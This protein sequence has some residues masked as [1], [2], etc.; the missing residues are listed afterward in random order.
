MVKLAEWIKDVAQGRTAEGEPIPSVAIVAPDKEETLA[1]AEKASVM[2]KESCSHGR[3]VMIDIPAV[4]IL[5][6]ALRT[7]DILYYILRKLQSSYCR[8]FIYHQDRV[9]QWIC[10]QAG[11]NHLVLHKGHCGESPRHC[12]P[13]KIEGARVQW[14]FDPVRRRT[15][16]V[17]EGG[18]AQRD[19]REERGGPAGR[20]LLGR[21]RRQ[22]LRPPPYVGAP[23]AS[24]HGS[25]LHRAELAQADQPASPGSSDCHLSL[26]G[27]WLERDG[28]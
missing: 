24:R 1:I 14:R 6:R 3:S 11:E 8:R 18:G 19:A 22:G 2:W 4:H 7:R 26:A 5:S 28:A 27:H 12:Q 9:C 16:A 13:S 20:R 25:P 15:A 23:A 17:L 10:S 21:R